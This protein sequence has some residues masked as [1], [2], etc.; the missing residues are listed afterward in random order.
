MI[1]SWLN[2]LTEFFTL[3]ALHNTSRPLVCGILRQI[4]TQV[5]KKACAGAHLY[6]AHCGS[7]LKCDTISY[8]KYKC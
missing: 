6:P 5:Y 1:Y 7:S 8:L 4:R 3:K 2:F